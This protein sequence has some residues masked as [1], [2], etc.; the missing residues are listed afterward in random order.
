MGTRAK[1]TEVHVRLY[2]EDVRALKKSAAEKGL[3]WNIELRQLVRL[4]LRGERR[5]IT[6]VRDS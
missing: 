4:A 2:S 1:L 3:P 6:I 5:E